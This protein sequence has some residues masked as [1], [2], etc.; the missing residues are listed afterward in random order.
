MNTVCWQ[1][2]YKDCT[3]PVGAWSLLALGSPSNNS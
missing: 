2:P 1:M 3:S